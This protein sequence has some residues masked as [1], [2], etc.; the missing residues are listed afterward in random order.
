MLGHYVTYHSTPY[1]VI[2][3]SS[4]CVHLARP[5]EDVITVDT[6]SVEPTNIP[7]LQ[8]IGTDIMYHFITAKGNRL[9]SFAN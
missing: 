7:P 8:P 2:A 6:S 3:E 1:L 5:N 4:I 9:P